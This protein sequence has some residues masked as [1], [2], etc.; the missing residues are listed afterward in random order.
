MELNNENERIKRRYYKYMEKA[1]RFSADTICAHERAVEQ[2]EVYTRY[3]E[4]RRI[5]TKQAGDF[6]GWLKA[7]ENKGKPLS[8]STQYQIVRL[9]KAFYLWLATQ[10]GRNAKSITVA[11]GYLTVERETVAEATSPG[12]RKVPS[13]EYIMALV[14]SITETDEIARRDRAMI[15]FLLLSGA[16]ASAVATLPLGCFERVNL[17][18]HQDPRRGV[19]TKNRKYIRTTLVL[20]SKGLLSHFLDWVDYLT[21][22][23][24]YGDEAPIFPRTK[25]IQPEGGLSYEAAGV[26]PVFWADGSRVDH[27]VKERARKAG[28]EPYD[29]HSFRHTHVKLGFSSGR[30]GEEFKAISQNIGHAHFAT[31]A[32][33]YS[34]LEEDEVSKIVSSLDFEG[35]SVKKLSAKQQERMFRKLLET[36]D[37]TDDEE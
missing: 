13:L 12:R 18:V 28:L 3:R 37:L 8:A 7:R 4:F 14:N 16:R 27:I 9:V 24:L 31:T 34:H 29:C 5:T 22:T 30:T 19:K 11:L 32:S 21:K 35:K 36:F 25:V 6:A 23:K 26:E 20:F 15:A 2:W 17:V 1:K 33:V 10:P